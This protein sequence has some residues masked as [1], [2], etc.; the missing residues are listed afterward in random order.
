MAER[1]RKFTGLEGR[2]GPIKIKVVS[3]DVY[4]IEVEKQLIYVL[5]LRE[6]HE[7]GLNELGLLTLRSG[8][9]TRFTELR[10]IDPDLAY[11]IMGFE[12]SS[13][14]KPE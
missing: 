5:G 3:Q 7:D 2:T 14:K 1:R 4:K 12:C 13:G 9:L 10:R 11:R 6:K 8:I